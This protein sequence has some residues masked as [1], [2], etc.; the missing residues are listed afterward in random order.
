[1]LATGQGRTVR[2]FCRE[3]FAHVGLDW[4]DHVTYDAHYERPSEVDVLIGDPT[5]AAELLGWTAKTH[6]NELA[7][8]MVDADM[9]QLKRLLES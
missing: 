3:A 6:A 1:M 9:E 2:D 7:R 5:K 4:E 8:L